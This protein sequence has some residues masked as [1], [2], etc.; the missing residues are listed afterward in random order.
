MLY[1]RYLRANLRESFGH[2]GRD[3]TVIALIAYGTAVIP[4]WVLVGSENVPAKLASALTLAAVFW[5]V[6]LVFVVTPARWWQKHSLEPEMRLTRLRQV[7]PAGLDSDLLSWLV[8]QHAG[9]ATGV[10]VGGLPHH[11]VSEL[12]LHDL[13]EIRDRT[14]PKSGPFPATLEQYAYL[15]AIGNGVVLASTGPAAPNRAR[16]LRR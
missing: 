8:D 11:V 5:F 3:E 13:I 14:F 12:Q 7:Y 15:S 10:P 1:V 2:W 9:F 4:S 16:S 6:A